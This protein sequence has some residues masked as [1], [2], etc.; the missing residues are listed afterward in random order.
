VEILIAYKIKIS[1]NMKSVELE[2]LI[3]MLLEQA[4]LFQLEANEFYPFGGL[5]NKSGDIVPLGVYM[6]NDHPDSHEV[7]QL[8]EKAILE[9][10]D[11]GEAKLAAI[12][13]DVF[14]KAANENIKKSAIQIRVVSETRDSIDY[15]LPYNNLDGEFSYEQLISG[16]GT[17]GLRRT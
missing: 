17:L 9:K 14:Y 13:A 15:Y 16:D 6:E 3:R 10:I 1:K 12:C 11:A 2:M 7:I 5:I 8:L 4:K